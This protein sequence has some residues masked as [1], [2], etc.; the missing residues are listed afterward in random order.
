MAKEEEISCKR[1]GACCYY[2]ARDGSRKKCRFLVILRSDPPSTL[3]RVYKTRLGRIVGLGNI[4]FVVCS[5]RGA[6]LE[7]EL[8]CPYNRV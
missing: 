3:C 5:E 1:C 6:H 2:T 4:G 8:G 7:N